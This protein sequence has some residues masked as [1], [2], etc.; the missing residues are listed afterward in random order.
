MKTNNTNLTAKEACIKAHAIRKETGCSL[1]DAF[2]AV[3]ANKNSVP[4]K[5]SFFRREL[6]EIYTSLV[7]K[8]LRNG[9][10]INTTRMAGSQGEIAHIDLTKGDKTIRI[11]MDN[12]YNTGDKNYDLLWDD[13]DRL[14]ILV[15]EVADDDRSTIWNNHLKVIKKQ[16]F[17]KLSDNFYVTPDQMPRIA[18]LRRNRFYN[19]GVGNGFNSTDKKTLFSSNG[20]Y[21]TMDEHDKAHALCESILPLVR[22]QQGCKGT[23]VSDIK[24]IVRVKSKYT[25]HYEI[26]IAKPNSTKVFSF[27]LG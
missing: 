26:A 10:I 11:L 3:Y 18:E 5:A 9:Y 13:A 14:V 15:G 4:R 20:V 24:S 19:F 6:D 2:K 7:T 22:R 12:G 16:V 1:S 17:C 23:K 25:T 21:A 27:K 8:Y